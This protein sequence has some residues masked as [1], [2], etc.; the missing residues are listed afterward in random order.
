MR[1]DPGATRAGVERP[2]R[3]APDE[4]PLAASTSRA[5]G[6]RRG[7][8]PVAE[9]PLAASTSRAGAPEVRPD[10]G[11]EELSGARRAFKSVGAFTR[12]VLLIVAVGVITAGVI[13]VAV[14]ALY[15]LAE[16]SV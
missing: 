3:S 13:A 14:A 5:G 2:G 9:T 4:T 6:G 1:P 15:T 10:F 16:S 11:P 12:W 8:T 7:R